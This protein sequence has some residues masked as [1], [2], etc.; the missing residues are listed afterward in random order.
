MSARRVLLAFLAVA[1][2]GGTALFGAAAGGT[3]VYLAARSQLDTVSPAP[4]PVVV[5]P[6]SQSSTL[7][8]D[9]NSAVQDAVAR[10]S[11]AVVTVVNYVR[12]SAAGSGSGVIISPDG[13][14]VTNNHVVEGSQSLEVI[15]QDGSTADAALLGT[16]PFVDIAVLK[17]NAAVPA[18]AEFGNSDVL[19]PGETVIA[20]GSPLGDFRNTVTVGVVS[21]TGRSIDTASNYTMEG[22]IQTD[23]AINHGNSGGPLVNL[24]GQVIGIN[25]LVVRGSGFSVDQA[26]GLGFAVASNEVNAIAKQLIEQGYVARPY[27]GVSWE[28]VTPAVARLYG[29]GSEWGVY[30]TTVYD[31]SPAGAAGIREGDIITALDGVTLDAEHPF[32]NALWDHAAGDEVKL[33]VVRGRDSLTVS[34]T[35]AE[36]PRS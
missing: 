5:E 25:T 33:T 4:D 17:V 31:A 32:I 28:P 29:L 30:I 6:A 10:V 27:L 11:P 35:L 21:A 14:I 26:E 12:G 23:A 7:T 15:F 9:V 36:R 19:N 2:M 1:A 24:A 22:L 8:V 13:Y 18:S 16:D 3:A 20:I 34:V